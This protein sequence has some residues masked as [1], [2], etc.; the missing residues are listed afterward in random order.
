ALAAGA[1]LLD[2]AR[3]IIDAVDALPTDL[4]PTLVER[5]ERHLIGLA[6]G[7]AARA[8]RPAPPRPRPDPGRA[9]RA[10]PDRPGRRPRRPRPEDPGPRAADGDRP[11]HRGRP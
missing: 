9:R 6:A 1:V 8:Q 7:P 3:V 5:A 4:D 11:R 10:A 2:Q